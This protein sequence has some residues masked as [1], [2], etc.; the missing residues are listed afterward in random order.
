MA[1]CECDGCLRTHK[2]ASAGIN[3]GY[4]L[5]T[6][7]TGTPYDVYSESLFCPHKLV[8]SSSGQYRHAACITP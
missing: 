4:K 3:P 6:Q 2:M 5:R 7:L 1:I 8:G